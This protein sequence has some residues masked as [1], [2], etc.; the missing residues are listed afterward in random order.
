MN[1]LP[2][3]CG[4]LTR[5]KRPPAGVPALIVLELTRAEVVSS[6]QCRYATT[7]LRDGANS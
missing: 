2:P 3:G 6:S 5:V 4:R 1:A 7:I